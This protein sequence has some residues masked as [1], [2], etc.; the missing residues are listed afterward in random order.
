[1]FIVF[2]VSRSVKISSGSENVI[3]HFVRVT[4]TWSTNSIEAR[5]PFLP[6]GQRE[7]IGHN[8]R[9]P[10][11]SFTSMRTAYAFLGASLAFLRKPIN[12]DDI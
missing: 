8:E 5:D 2:W 9:M 7:T 6:F 1:M 10:L 3:T 12:S 4:R 11:M